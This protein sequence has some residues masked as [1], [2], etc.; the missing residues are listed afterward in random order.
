MKITVDSK[1][2]LQG[3]VNIC[4]AALRTGE[5]SVAKMVVMLVESASVKVEKPK[6]GKTNDDE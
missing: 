4:S 1:E 2:T 3:L 5:L 6:K